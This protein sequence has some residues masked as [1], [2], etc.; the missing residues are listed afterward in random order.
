MRT[1]SLSLSRLFPLLGAPLVCL[2]ALSACGNDT[3]VNEEANE[4]TAASGTDDTDTNGTSDTND[5]NTEAP[6]TTDTDEGS[7]FIGEEGADTDTEG[8]SAMLGDQC[9]TNSDCAEDLF[10][11]GIPGFG[12][13]CSTCNSDSDCTDG[14]NCTLGD[15]GYFDCGDGSVGQMCESD[16][17]CADDLYCAEVANLGGL[18]NGNF[19]S[20]CKDDSHCEPEQLCAPSIEFTSI[21]DV[22]GQRSCIEPGTI[23]NDQLC[24]HDGAGDEQCINYCTSASLMGL[25][26]VGICGDCETD[27]DCAEGTTCMA[28]VLGLDGFAGSVCG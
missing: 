13:I 8:G 2:A 21:T 5:D 18:V 6:A 12:G 7:N 15:Q 16:D 1:Q 20:E 9:S 24:D 27:D 11:N 3:S 23:E 28:A 17:V 14:G 25:I 19:C 22:S 26:T 10:C 4:T